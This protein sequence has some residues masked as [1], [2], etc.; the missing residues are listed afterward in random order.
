MCPGWLSAPL[1]PLP[2]LSPLSFPIRPS[3]NPFPFPSLTPFLNL[4]P[5]IKLTFQFP[6]PPLHSPPLL[7]STRPSFTFPSPGPQKRATA[8]TIEASHSLPFPLPSPSPLTILSPLPATI[9]SLIV[10]LPNVKII[11]HA[12]FPCPHAC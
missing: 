4:F 8:A 2:F 3:L 1:P 12:A 10:L 7:H 6:H 9:S 11:V 5:F